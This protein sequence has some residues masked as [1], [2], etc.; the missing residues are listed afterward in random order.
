M[1][2]P[3]KWA[4]IAQF[5]ELCFLCSS[6]ALR[7]AAS[8]LELVLFVEGVN[9]KAGKYDTTERE[10]SRIETNR[11]HYYLRDPD[12]AHDDTVSEMEARRGDVDEGRA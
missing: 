4:I 9:T 10:M 8:F 11:E 6:D 12:P 3:E 2:I 5:F 7:L 1:H